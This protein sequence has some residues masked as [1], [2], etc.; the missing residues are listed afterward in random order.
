MENSIKES[1]EEY[2]KLSIKRGN[3]DTYRGLLGW[4]NSK[5]HNIDYFEG[6]DMG[7]M[8]FNNKFFDE[9]NEGKEQ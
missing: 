2:K 6:L 9:L 5:G 7:L 3:V 8:D 1:L 4:L